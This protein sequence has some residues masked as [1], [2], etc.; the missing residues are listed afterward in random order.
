[1]KSQ[2]R[3]NGS[4]KPITSW[5]GP[6]EGLGPPTHSSLAPPVRDR[7]RT[8]LQGEEPPGPSLL[9]PHESYSLVS[10]PSTLLYSAAATALSLLQRP[11]QA[12][13]PPRSRFSSDHRK[14][15][16]L[17]PGGGGRGGRRSR[18][19][20]HGLRCAYIRG[21]SGG[22]RGRGRPGGR[23]RLGWARRRRRVRA[24]QRPQLRLRRLPLPLR[25]GPRQ[26][27]LHCTHHPLLV[28]TN[29]VLP[30]SSIGFC[31]FCQSSYSASG[32]ELEMSAFF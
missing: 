21:R 17:T 30:V 3:T 20:R 6:Y 27:L 7:P 2:T 32:G 23:V 18:R 31:S 15:G 11:P 5:A 1:V 28:F 14:Q 19:Q 10:C 8:L 13:K 22:E 24:H 12:R 25:Q 4:L 16:N 29:S 26:A 9:V